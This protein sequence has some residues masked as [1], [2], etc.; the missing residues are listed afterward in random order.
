ME[1]ETF[2]HERL[3][4]FLAPGEGFYAA[5]M[6]NYPHAEK[7]M[8][9]RMGGTEPAR[10]LVSDSRVAVWAPI[11]LPESAAGRI[12]IYP[13]SA[14]KRNDWLVD[15]ITSPPDGLFLAASVGQSGSDAANW[16]LS[17]DKDLIAF[18]G[19]A[20]LFD[21][22]AKVLIERERFLASIAWFKEQGNVV[23]DLLRHKDIQRR[24]KTGQQSGAEARA[25]MQR[26]KTPIETLNSYPGS[27]NP[28]VIRLASYAAHYWQPEGREQ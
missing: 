23:S 22:Q 20:G 2:W 12:E 14:R 17:P 24:F 10:F 13:T 25:S 5:L 26:L 4:K 7:S 8:T 9:T 18:G 1:A 21:G 15:V 28:A 27:R 3:G 11:R 6:R 19:A 16:T